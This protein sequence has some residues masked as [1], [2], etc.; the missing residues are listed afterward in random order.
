MWVCW[1]AWGCNNYGRVVSRFTITTNATRRVSC[2]ANSHGLPTAE[3]IL[4]WVEWVG[5][6]VSSVRP[7]LRTCLS[8][9][10]GRRTPLLRS[11][12]SPS[13]NW[14]LPNR[15]ASVLP[16]WNP[17]CGRKIGRCWPWDDHRRGNQS[18][19]YR[20]GGTWPDWRVH[21][22]RQC[23]RHASRRSFSSIPRFELSLRCPKWCLG[24]PAISQRL[25]IKSHSTLR[26][27]R[28]TFTFWVDKSWLK[29]P[30]MVHY[31]EFL[32][33]W[34]LRS[35]SGSRQVSFN[36]TKVGGKCQNSK[37]IE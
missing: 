4:D 24:I 5:T 14:P 6:A 12:T 35:K 8:S 23:L 28:A 29:M 10:W 2:W 26:A 34:S 33:S 17:W 16:Q 7:R 37:V 22:F 36:R 30:N 27:K 9:S 15:S 18:R 3:G 13:H 19:R 25:K 31:G 21:A 1:G 32:K 20:G 11:L